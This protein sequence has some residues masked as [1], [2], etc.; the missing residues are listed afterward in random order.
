MGA[1]TGVGFVAAIGGGPAIA[2]IA[3]LAGFGLIAA[4]LLG[5]PRWLILPVIVL[6]LPLAVVSAADLDLNGGVGERTDRPLSAADI[7]PEYRIGIGHVDLD[8]R[9]VTL[10]AGRTE[11]KL[12]VGMGEALVRVP[13]GMCVVTDA[14]IGVGAADLPE[15]V[16]EGLDIVVDQSSA[17]LGSRP[18]LLVTADVGVGH[19]QIDRAGGPESDCA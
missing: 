10:P 17:N 1:A 2:V 8:L 18:Q 14:Q 12:R 3:I 4:G 9:G 13:A 11:V 7:R 6:V 19:L 16:D 15:R 5:G